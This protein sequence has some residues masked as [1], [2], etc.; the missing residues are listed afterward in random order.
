MNLINLGIHILK[1]HCL[2]DAE[3][4]SIKELVIHYIQLDECVAIEMNAVN[5]ETDNTLKQSKNDCM[6]TPATENKYNELENSQ[7][8]IE[9][10]GK[11]N[12]NR[13]ML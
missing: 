3:K 12:N 4:Q 1:S 2:T 5:N 8:Q 9:N 11:G 10:G 7:P 13:N 6:K